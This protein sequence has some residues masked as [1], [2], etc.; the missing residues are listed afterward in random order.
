MRARRYKD[1]KPN[2]LENGMTFTNG[3]Q[4]VKSQTFS[5]SNLDIKNFERSITVP[6]KRKLDSDQLAQNKAKKEDRLT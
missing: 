4:T 6:K 5:G 1:T 3:T 2:N